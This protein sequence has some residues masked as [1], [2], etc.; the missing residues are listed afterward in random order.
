MSSVKLKAAK[1]KMQNPQ[2][3]AQQEQ[4]CCMASYEFDEKQ[5]TKPKFVAQSRSAFYFLQQLSSTGSKC[6]C[7]M[8][9]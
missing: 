5:V 6:F 7:C 4:I 2:V 9:S 1:H 3:V 8:T